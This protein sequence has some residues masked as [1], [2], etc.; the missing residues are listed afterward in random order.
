VLERD[1]PAVGE[2]RRVEGAQ[3]V[4]AA[5]DERAARRLAGI[6]VGLERRDDRVD[7]AGREGALVLGH[8]VRL[9]QRGVGLVQRRAVQVPSGQLPAAVVDPQLGEPPVG[10]MVADDRE[11]KLDAPVRVVVEVQEHL[12]E[13]AG[14][15]DDVVDVVDGDVARLEPRAE[16]RDERPE[17]RLALDATADRVVDD[18]LAGERLDERIGLP[19]EQPV[20]VRHR[21]EL[22]APAGVED[23]L[24]R[25]RGE[26]LGHPGHARK[27]RRSRSGARAGHD[28]GR[29]RSRYRNRSAVQPHGC[30]GGVNRDLQRL[31]RRP[32]PPGRGPDQRLAAD[33]PHRARPHRAVP[34]RR[35]GG[36]GPVPPTAG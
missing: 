23:V 9:V 28:R 20:E 10:R 18:G 24:E 26:Q 7:V 33:L 19:R 32:L 21:D 16:L 14:L 31:P 12:L 17:R 36:P 34:P 13:A 29:L 11:R 5:V 1:A 15:E 2:H 4:L 8:D 25:R 3:L 35:D 27:R 30:P 6:A 22:V